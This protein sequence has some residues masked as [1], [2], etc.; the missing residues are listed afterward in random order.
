MN[1]VL[2]W[3]I[4]SIAALQVPGEQLGDVSR[5]IQDKCDAYGQESAVG[6]LIN[7]MYK[8]LSYF[9]DSQWLVRAFNWIVAPSIRGI[10]CEVANMD[11]RNADPNGQNRNST[12]VNW[13]R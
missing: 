10:T 2:R 13:G 6:R 3:C 1:R 8:A 11:L 5:L 12:Q 4:C 9:D 7:L